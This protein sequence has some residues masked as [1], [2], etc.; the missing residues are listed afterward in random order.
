[1][2]LKI[3]KTLANQR[4]IGKNILNCRTGIL[5]LQMFFILVGINGLAN[6]KVKYKQLPYEEKIKPERGL[7]FKLTFDKYSVI[8]DYAKGNAVPIKG[9]DINLQLRG[10]LGFDDANALKKEKNERLVYSVPGNIDHKKGTIF[11]WIKAENYDPSSKKEDCMKGYLNIKLKNGHEWVEFTFYHYFVGGKGIFYW[12]NSVPQD[13]YRTLTIYLDKISEK[14]WFQIA[15]TW[16]EKELKI[17]LNGALQGTISLPEKVTETLSMQPNPTESAMTIMGYM[18]GKESPVTNKITLIDDISIYDYPMSAPLIKAKYLGITNSRE[19][20]KELPA[21]GIACNGIDRG[22]GKLGDVEF[23]LDFNSLP[24]KFYKKLAAGDLVVNYEL[25]NLRWRASWIPHLKDANINSPYSSFK[26]TGEWQIKNN[27]ER[28]TLNVNNGGKYLLNLNV[29][30]SEGATLAVKKSFEIPDISFVG[31]KIGE[32]D[33]VP[34]PW[35]PVK[36]ENGNVISVWNRKYH[37]LDGP[38][39]SK[40]DAGGKNI[41]KKAPELM[42]KTTSGI[43][44]IK[45]SVIAVKVNEKN[46]EIIGKGVAKDFTLKFNTIVE[47]DGLINT[48]FT[49]CGS[50]KIESMKICWTVSPEFSDYF[51]SPVYNQDIKAEYEYPNENWRCVRQLWLA[52]EQAGF[53]WAPANDA[54]WVY[55]T[56]EKILKIDRSK[57]GGYCEINLITQK[58][59]LPQETPYQILFIATPTRPAPHE[60]YGLNFGDFH[61]YTDK[62]LVSVNGVG[63]TAFGEFTPDTIDFPGMAENRQPNSLAI[64]NFATSLTESSL[65]GRFFANYWDFPDMPIYNMPWSQ[66]GVLTRTRTINCC[67]TTAYTDFIMSGIK[68]LLDSKYGDRVWAIYYDIC[69]INICK[70]KLHGCSY[71]DKFGRWVNTN[72]ILP[73]REILKR[74]TSYS[75]QRGRRTIY[76]AQNTFN[77]M[78]HAFGDYWYGGEQFGSLSRKNMFAYCDDIPDGVFRSELNR[79]I[80]GSALLFLP[81]LYGENCTTETTRA[82]FTQLLLHD[83]PTSVCYL[84]YKVGKKI[85]NIL[86]RYDLDKA[87]ARLYYENHNVISSDPEVKITYYACNYNR[88]L[89]V[90]ANRSKISRKVDIDV[91]SLKNGD[92]TARNEYDNS[93]VLVKNGKLEVTIPARDFLLIGF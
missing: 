8:A 21:V 15:A 38:F 30:D 59:E 14:Q 44:E 72:N 5:F 56:G 26:R 76:H 10:I 3:K 78:A 51:L 91:S 86:T 37:F 32:E 73:L 4:N 54:N 39:P 31:N 90:L 55:K 64:Y 79:R 92:F 7:T 75:H 52:S 82:M 45:Y 17:Y 46:A 66:H 1:M 83:I 68:R 50:P 20:N 40:V 84:D 74:T 25:V 88:N 93:D 47:Y 13:K 33:F 48:T 2:M 18:D 70:N 62:T 80:L 85:F 53:C 9:A 61:N 28:R 58:V 42:I 49:I 36:L 29:I 23:E 22:D 63:Q 6:E 60:L 69:V 34:Y 89:L 19:N 87:V 57:D 12:Q 67:P 27:I 11:F 81:T 24:E 65:T 16:D 77:P 71:Q 41:L 43:A 35:T